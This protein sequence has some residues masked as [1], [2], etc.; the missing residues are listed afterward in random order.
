MFTQRQSK[1]GKILVKQVKN[2]CVF[3]VLFLQLSSAFEIFPNKQE[4]EKRRNYFDKVIAQIQIKIRQSPG[5]YSGVIEKSQ[6][7]YLKTGMT[8]LNVPL[9]NR[10]FSSVYV[11]KSNHN[12]M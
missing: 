6:K 11:S 5:C 1:C 3:T 12:N 2:I 9:P 8:W 7:Q 4:E 10:K